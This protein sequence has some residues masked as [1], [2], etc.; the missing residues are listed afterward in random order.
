MKVAI[1]RAVGD[2]GLQDPSTGN[3][4]SS[5]RD[6]VVPYSNWAESLVNHGQIKVVE[7]LDGS[8]YGEFINHVAQAD[9]DED[10]ALSS[11]RKVLP[12][13]TKGAEKVRTVKDAADLERQQAEE[14]ETRTAPKTTVADKA[15]NK[16]APAA[17]P[18]E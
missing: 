12:A 2:G 13:G 15:P 18:A 5:K 16:D 11:Y 3:Y 4:V 7:I 6:T 17:K 8:D 14:K 1:L 10:K 9:G